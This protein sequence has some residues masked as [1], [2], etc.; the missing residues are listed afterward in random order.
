V[1]QEWIYQQ[2]V[3]VC[4]WGEATSYQQFIKYPARTSSRQSLIKRLISGELG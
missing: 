1:L 3:Q 4:R 2:L